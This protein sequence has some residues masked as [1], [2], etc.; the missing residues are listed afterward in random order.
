[1]IMIIICGV[2]LDDKVVTL[3]YVPLHSRHT[4]QKAA[5]KKELPGSGAPEPGRAKYVDQGILEAKLEA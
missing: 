2:N 3:R 5:Q 1:M 4:A